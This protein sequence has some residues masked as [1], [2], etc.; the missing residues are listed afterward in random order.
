MSR[1][2]EF[3]V[4]SPPSWRALVVEAKLTPGVKLTLLILSEF[5]SGMGAMVWPGKTKLAELAGVSVEQVEKALKT[6]RSLG[7]LRYNPPMAG[8]SSSYSPSLPDGV[9][10]GNLMLPFNRRE[11]CQ[12][13]EYTSIE[14]AKV[15]LAK[16]L[17]LLENPAVYE[18]LK[19]FGGEIRNIET[20]GDE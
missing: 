12:G 6:A 3:Y 1:L 18:I 13:V 19:T 20:L 9:S 7:W 16:Q 17:E 10:P 11:E 14:D 4:G 5:M 15:R 8:H 2:P